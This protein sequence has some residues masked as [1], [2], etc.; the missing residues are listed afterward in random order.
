M[1][2]Q[3]S[4]EGRGFGVRDYRSDGLILSTPLFRHPQICHLLM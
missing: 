4:V 1:S 2:L 3:L